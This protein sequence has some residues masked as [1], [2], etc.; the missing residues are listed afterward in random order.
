[1]NNQLQKTTNNQVASLKNVLASPSVQ[2]QFK[3]A[4]AEKSSLFVASII[5]LYAGDNYL[6]KCNPQAVVMEALK[7]ATL[8]LPISKSLGFAYIVPYKG[9]PVFQ[10]GYKGM[11]QL[12]MRTGQYRYIN[13]GEILE[14]EFVSFDKLTGELD[15]SGQPTSETVVGYF[16]HIETVNGFRKSMY[17]T[18]ERMEA[19]AAKYSQQYGNKKMP[20]H[21]EFDK[22]ATKTML[23]SLLSKYGVMSVEMANAFQAEDN[24]TPGSDD[25]LGDGAVDDRPIVIDAESGE[26]SHEL[27]GKTSA[28]VDAELAAAE[29]QPDMPPAGPSF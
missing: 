27:D 18:R 7:A 4:L 20:W 3:N 13:A 8:D 16:A 29:G 28:Q 14:G 21:T 24:Q 22:M 15:I 1:M 25:M 10:I 11:I 6:Q 12:A 2:E 17:W 9:R 5:D 26:I 19:H 23:R